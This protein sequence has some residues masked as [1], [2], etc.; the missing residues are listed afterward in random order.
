MNGR[1]RREYLEAIFS[2][3]RQADLAQKQVILNEFCRNRSYNRIR[4]ASLQTTLGTYGKEI[5]VSDQHRAGAQQGR[6]DDSSEGG[7]L[8][9]R[10]EELSRD[11]SLKH[12]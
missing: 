8:R 7:K 11:H 12:P 10:N 4:H 5:E 2:R 1:S 3:Y 6:E 9:M